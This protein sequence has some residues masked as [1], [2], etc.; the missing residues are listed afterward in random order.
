MQSQSLALSRT[1][2]GLSQG[3][4]L[5]LLYLAHET[6]SWPAT[7]GLLFAALLVPAVYVPPM[8]VAALGHFRWPT[9]ATWMIVA[10]AVCAG[11]GWYDIFRD[12]SGGPVTTAG[13]R[14]LPTP[15]LWLSLGAA[16]FITHALVGAGESDRRIVAK[17]QTYFDAS[18]KLAIQL[19]LA[20]VFV[21]A[22]WLLL[23]LGAELFRLIRIEFLAELISR[24]SE[25]NDR[26]C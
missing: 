18:W 23:W 25:R 10:L 9:L 14:I 16:L 17:Y 11:L 3:L 7:D 26:K 6:E 5:Y 1:V 24:W 22:M 2:I 13:V 15:G 20:G 12:P 4:G 19:V 21:G 8:L